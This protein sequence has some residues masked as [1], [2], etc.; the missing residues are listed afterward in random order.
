MEACHFEVFFG[1]S[2]VD[3]VLRYKPCKSG[4]DLQSHLWITLISAFKSISM[5]P[6]HSL[7]KIRTKMRFLSMLCCTVLIFSF[8]PELLNRLTRRAPVSS[9]WDCESISNRSQIY[10]GHESKNSTKSA[11]IPSSTKKYPKL[12]TEP[13][14]LVS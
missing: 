4:S 5:Y 2:L 12:V 14:T 8:N 9:S 10:S 7:E 1:R 3:V 13:R 6:F 11:E